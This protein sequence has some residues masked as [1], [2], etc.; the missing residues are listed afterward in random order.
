[1]AVN[2]YG[3]LLEAMGRSVAQIHTALGEIAPDLYRAIN[4][5]TP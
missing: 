5:G 3:R 1:M 2:N 4:Q